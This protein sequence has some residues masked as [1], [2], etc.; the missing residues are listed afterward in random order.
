MSEPKNSL[1]NII[2]SM[3]MRGPELLNYKTPAIISIEENYA[4]AFYE[5]LIKMV[6]EF[7]DRLD[8]DQGRN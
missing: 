7:Y 8:Q 3:T 6:K 4:S 1:D 2:K 5:R